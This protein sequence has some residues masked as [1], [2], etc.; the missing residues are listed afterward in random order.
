LRFVGTFSSQNRHLS[1]ANRDFSI[2]QAQSASI[3]GRPRGNLR[4]KN[5][6]S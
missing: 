2:G 6:R 4:A 1:G 5:L 3:C